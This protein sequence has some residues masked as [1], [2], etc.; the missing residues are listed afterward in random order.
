[1]P[2][3][4]RL[5][6]FL[7]K[8]KIRAL[9]FIVLLLNCTLGPPNLGVGGAR[10]PGAPPPPDPLVEIYFDYGGKGV[11]WIPGVLSCLTLN[12]PRPTPSDGPAVFI[13]GHEC[14]IQRSQL[15]LRMKDFLVEFVV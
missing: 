15:V 12:L 9:K 4:A 3:K 11:N 2:S 7:K 10:A 1:M 8:Y 5:K 13:P 6:I 14:I